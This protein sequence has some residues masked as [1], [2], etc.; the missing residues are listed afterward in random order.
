V[1]QLPL[2]SSQDRRRRGA[3]G[4]RGG[5]SKFTSPPAVASRKAEFRGKKAEP[6]MDRKPVKAELGV[7][8]AESEARRRSIT[9]RLATS[10]SR[11]I[12]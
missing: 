10:E 6:Q 9:M 11:V 3:A 7:D 8:K 12:K 2:L 1:Q 5:R 4:P